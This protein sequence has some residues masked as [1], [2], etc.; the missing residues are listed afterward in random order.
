MSLHDVSPLPDSSELSPRLQK[1]VAREAGKPA[2]T[3]ERAENKKRRKHRN[4]PSENTEAFE[5]VMECYAG[6][7]SPQGLLIIH[8]AGGVSFADYRADCDIA[9]KRVLSKTEWAIFRSVWKFHTIPEDKVPK[10]V[11]HYIKTS[12][13]RSLRSRRLHDLFSYF[14]RPLSN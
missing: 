6:V 10:E 2:R 8:G 9:I 11:V 3:G 12:A 5:M 7:R 4:L 13:G 14:N 1:L